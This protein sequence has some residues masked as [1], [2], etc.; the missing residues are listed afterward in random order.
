M[1]P[2]EYNEEFKPEEYVY[3]LVDLDRNAHHEGEG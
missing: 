3:K 2:K 1:W